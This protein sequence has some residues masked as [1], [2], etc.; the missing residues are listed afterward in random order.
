MTL[1]YTQLD[2]ITDGPNWA[3]VRVMDFTPGE[4]FRCLASVELPSKLA[5]TVY[6]SP[7]DEDA[8]LARPAFRR[9]VDAAI[10]EARRVR[11]AELLP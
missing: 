4:P 10:T 1:V 6:N 5:R 11:A 9:Y 3:A 8:L 2:L 7:D